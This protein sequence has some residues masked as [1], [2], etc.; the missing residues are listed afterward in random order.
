MAIRMLI[1]AG[2]GYLMTPAHLINDDIPWENIAAPFK[3]AE[4][5]G[6]Y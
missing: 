2:G 3:A 1:G 4:K 5:Y 6:N